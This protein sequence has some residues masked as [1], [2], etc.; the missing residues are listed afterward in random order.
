[1]SQARKHLVVSSDITHQN[2]EALLPRDLNQLGWD[3]SYN[4]PRGTACDFWIVFSV[5]RGR[6]W[7]RC[8]QDNT[9]YLAG[10]PPSKKVHPK[11]FYSQFAQIV[12]LNSSDPH[13]QVIVECPCLNWHVGLNQK[14]DCYEYGYHRLSN[15]QPPKK[16]RRISVVC[17]NLRTTPGQRARL[18]FLAALKMRLGDRIVHYGRGFNPVDDKMDAIL[19]YTCHL[20]L[21]NECTPHYWTEKLADAYLGF[22]FPFYLGAP[23][24]GDYFPSAS[25]S[26]INPKQID[27]VTTN[28]IQALTTN[29]VNRMHS[30]IE[31]RHRV[32]NRYN[33]FKNAIRLAD[34]AYNPKAKGTET[35]IWSH[36]AFRKFPKNYLFRIKQW[37]SF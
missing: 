31:A 30:V 21:E 1:M 26:I 33:L 18:E 5:V 4:P 35:I 23:N 9:L 11:S 8:A 6:D 24:L 36:K 20:V 37:S 15:M 34:A 32:L 10:E 19:P 7:M 27:Q 16:E 14:T 13:P 12:S 22:A 25:F 28:I 17:S 29:P 2:M 3:V